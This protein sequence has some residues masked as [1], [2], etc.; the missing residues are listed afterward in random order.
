MDIKLLA[1][2]DAK[3]LRH[4]A[5]GLSWVLPLIFMG[6]L[7][8]WFEYQW[9][10]YPLLVPI[11]LLPLA[12]LRPLWLYPFYRIWMLVFGTLAK[13]NTLLLLAIVFVLIITPMGFVARRLGKLHYNHNQIGNIQIGN[14]QAVQSNW[15]TPNYPPS[16]SHLK[17]P[18]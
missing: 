11:I 17:E 12:W 2:E 6:L 16:Q 9:S 14:K 13:L 4:F 3:G 8:W 18:F 15:Q 7:P 5:Y 10:Y 1:A